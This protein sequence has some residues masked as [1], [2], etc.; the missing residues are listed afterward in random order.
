[1]VA[2]LNERDVKKDG[3]S[4]ELATD[5]DVTFVTVTEEAEEEAGSPRTTV[6]GGAATAVH[7]EPGPYPATAAVTAVT[8]VANPLADAELDLD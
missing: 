8:A 6:D 7:V 2:E 5:A 4:H 3:A 1:M